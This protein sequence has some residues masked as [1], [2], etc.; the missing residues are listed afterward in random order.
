MITKSEYEN[1]RILDI[2]HY[3]ASIED[4]ITCG[5]F[6][7]MDSIIL[8]FVPHDQEAQLRLD[9]TTVMEKAGWIVK[10]GWTDNRDGGGELY[11]ELT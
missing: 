2:A 4:A 9:I 5:N 10:F 3:L 8:G 11:I 7:N 1:G 6:H